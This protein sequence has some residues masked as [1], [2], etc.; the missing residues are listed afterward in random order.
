MTS[1]SCHSIEIV[2]LAAQSTLEC[3]L[4][5]HTTLLEC[6]D[7]VERCHGNEIVVNAL[8]ITCTEGICNP[9]VRLISRGIL[10]SRD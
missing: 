8:P 7:R 2:F 6:Y 3:C 5:L 4:P 10:L 9:N 1:T